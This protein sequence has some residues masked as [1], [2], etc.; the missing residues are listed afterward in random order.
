MEYW[1]DLVSG[2]DLKASGGTKGGKQSGSGHQEEFAGRG[3][4]CEVT[5]VLQDIE[6][7]E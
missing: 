5:K 4:Q 2:M 6:H 7:K 1:Q 3:D